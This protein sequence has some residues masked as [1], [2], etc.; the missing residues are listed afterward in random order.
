MLKSAIVRIVDFCTR[1]PWWVLALALILS[2]ASAVYAARHFAIKTDINEL[3]S[4]QLPWTQRATEYMAAF[5]QRE[6][7]VVVDAPTPELVEQAATK[8]GETLQDR[9]DHIRAVRQLQSGSFFERNGLLFLSTEEVTRVTDG[10][11]RADALLE[12]LAADPSLRG[13]LDALS[14]GVMGV[15]RKE[16]K[17]DDMT[18][19][20]TLAADTAEDVLAGRPASFS[21]RVLAS[22]KPAQPRD[23]RRLIEVD[24][25][26][27]F[28][29]LQPGLAA[30]NAIA[31][32]AA[33]L[34]LA[35]NYRAR[36][37]QTGLVPIDDDEF[38][39]LKQNAGLNAT[40]SLLAVLL[41]LWLALRS[42]RIIFAV[43]VS[44][45]VGLAVS[46]AWGLFLVGAFNLISV[47]FFVLFVGLGIDFGIQFSVRYRAERHDY[48]ELPKALHS[49]AVKAGGPLALAAA[50]TAVG[51]SSFLPTAYRGLS[52]L[53]QIAGS[54]M[55]IAFISS[56]TVLPALLAI[57]KPPGEPHPMGFA[58]LAP[59]DAFLQRHRIA[60]VVLTVL[61]VVLASPLLLFLPFDFNPLHLRSPKV[62]SVATFLELRRDPET[63][64]NS[65]EIMTPNLAAA[66]ATAQRIANLP[67]V[68]RT[69][70]LQGLVP[71]DQDEK[72]KLIRAA[73]AAIDASLNPKETDPPPTDQENVEALS[74]T[75]DTLTKVAGN[76]QGPGADAARRL[77]GLLS[78]LAKSDPSARK[79]AE[80]AVVEPLRISLRQLRQELKPERITIE[81]I[82]RDL[83]REWV[84]PDGRARVQVLPK[85]D[86][87][88]TEVLRDFVTA[89]L[90]V[91]PDAT[92][93]AV[94][95]FEAGNTVV[96]AFV[97][98]GIFA[99]SAI[100]VL[101]WITLR[102]IT[103]VLLTLVP[104]LVAGV[105]TLELCVLIELPL[106][107]ADIIALPLLL[108]VG[109]AFKIYYIMAWRQGKT[110]LL[111]S[112]LTRAVIF[113]ALTTATA[114]GSLWLSSHPGTSSMG[115]L[116]AL[117]LVCT[118]AAAV[119]FQP[120]LM[121]PPRVKEET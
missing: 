12:T 32:T 121:G 107:F 29:A 60:V 91:E 55:I 35:E 76:Q 5:P 31:R 2:A 59:A 40:A 22:G 56:I 73:A 37:R 1:Y 65:V 114:F 14:F 27:D 103:D 30:T 17:L 69:M 33:D 78:R 90:A 77:S 72:L 82:P 87:D 85:G 19:P 97:Q 84:T 41:I 23:L 44:I 68:S 111:Q 57:L 63:G 118:M 16:L 9:H 99:L 64:A 106:N 15:E 58:W 120:A 34:H 11:T 89:I 92:G 86:P 46:V 70:T 24:P 25:V 88:N 7:L 80:T 45:T 26:L 62:E 112:S 36:V 81:N 6:V 105:V 74:S 94:S 61:V 28:S 10:L 54:G 66:D 3:I 39:T 83:A 20:M 75:A 108:G 71:K 98:A 42:F 53:G 117:A 96:E 4:K 100:A 110:A 48:D 101:L 21:W 50:A 38:G 113:S 47:A 52:E 109:V 51:F 116:M 119:L 43:A 13:T 104:L 67:Q 18:R 102:R 93:P 8:L 79:R 115:K 95:L 49:T